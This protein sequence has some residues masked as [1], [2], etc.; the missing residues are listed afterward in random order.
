MDL[1]TIIGGV[2]GFLTV[3]VVMAVSGSVLMYWDFLSLVIVLGGATFSS[4]MRWPVSNFIT[5]IHTGLGAIF[6]RLESPSELIDVI[7][8]LATKARTNSIISLE[9]EE[10]SNEFL[11][12]GIRLAVDGTDPE[13]IDEIL[14]EDIQVQKKKLANGRGIYE[15]MGEACPAFGMIG[16]VI[17]LIVI[18]GNL[19]D[20][21]KIGPGLAVA[22]VTTLYGALAANMFFIPISKKL[23][24]RSSEE[25]RNYQIIKTGIQGILTGINPKLIRERLETHLA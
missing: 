4:I 19:T 14:N 24:F 25:I 13:M 12:K 22:L 2:L 16:T 1:A 11:A 7:I 6:N 18:M 23:K 5:G 21:S 15:D 10:I 8:D 3:I 9:K 20:P 17:G